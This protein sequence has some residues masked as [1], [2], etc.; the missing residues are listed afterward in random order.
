MQIVKVDTETGEFKTWKENEF[1]FPGEAQFVSRPGAVSEDDGV[2][3][4]A[5]TDVRK[6]TPDFLLVLDAKDLSEIARAE[7]DVHVPNVIHG[8]FVPNQ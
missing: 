3:L 5:V 6:G 8:I 1:T 2:L 4:A 7:V